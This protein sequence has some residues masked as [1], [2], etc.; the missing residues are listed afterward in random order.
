MNEEYGASGDVHQ[1]R[2]GRIVV[3]VDGVA[4]HGV[5]CRDIMAVVGRCGRHELEGPGGAGVELVA[6]NRAAR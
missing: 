6:R 5:G 4:A 1:R 2:G 3:V